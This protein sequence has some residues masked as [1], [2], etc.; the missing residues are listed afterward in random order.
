MTTSITVTGVGFGV[1]KVVVVESDFG[2]VD[3]EVEDEVTGGGQEL[4]A[5]C[6][7]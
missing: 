3:I 1:A 6:V 7:W 4:A 5:G 2:T